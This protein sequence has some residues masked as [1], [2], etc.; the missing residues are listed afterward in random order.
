VSKK[1]ASSTKEP[2]RRKNNAA[3]RSPLAGVRSM[4]AATQVTSL[5]R[6]LMEQ[7]GAVG[8]YLGFKTRK[9]RRTRKPS[10]IC[11]VPR[12]RTPGDIEST[13][14]AQMIPRTV[15][16]TDVRGTTHDLLTDVAELQA[17]IA[18]QAFAGTGDDLA[19][20]TGEQASIGMALRHP[21]F[22][23]V[24]TTAAHALTASAGITEFPP[25]HAPRV[26]ISQFRGGAPTCQAAVLKIHLTRDGDYALLRPIEDVRCAN[27]YRDEAIVNRPYIPG[28][29][30]LGRPVVVL[31]PA[32]VRRTFF[33]GVH[34]QLVH[35]PTGV[36]MTNLLLTD[37]ATVPGDSGAC[38]ADVFNGDLR[39]WGL[40]VGTA[41]IDRVE[42][43]VFTHALSP[44]L[45]EQAD[46]LS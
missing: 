1:R 2:V 40:L 8:C 44:L 26:R 38:L 15:T 33:R 24:V 28:P 29:G 5:A 12:K 9:G 19:T 11:L 39:V 23:D 34:A 22:G 30:D 35:G 7:S 18:S 14:P 13:A 41:V 25:T 43:S 46:Y 4:P 31:G 36:L 45:L 21:K 20:S 10:V 37:S 32:G 17:P 16:W 42:F 3:T 27:L 6:D